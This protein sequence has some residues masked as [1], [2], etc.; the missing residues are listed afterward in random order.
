MVTIIITEV[1]G[2]DAALE[3]YPV[4]FAMVGV[5]LGIMSLIFFIHNHKNLAIQRKISLV[6]L[7]TLLFAFLFGVVIPMVTGDKSYGYMV[8]FPAK[9]VGIV[10]LYFCISSSILVNMYIHYQDLPAEGELS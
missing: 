8:S 3:T 2:I 6:W 9:C 7:L 5:F 10:L 1:A 4:N